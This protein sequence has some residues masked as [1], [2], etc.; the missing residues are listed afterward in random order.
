M[1]PPQQPPPPPQQQLSFGTPRALLPPL[2]MPTSPAL[3]RSGAPSTPARYD[4]LVSAAATAAT[5]AATAATAAATAAAATPARTPLNSN[6]LAAARF[7]WR[8]VG[9]MEVHPS[10][11][12]PDTMIDLTWELPARFV[13]KGALNS[14]RQSAGSGRD[15]T[16]QGDWIGLYR[17]RQRID[18][19]DGYV[20]TREVAGRMT[21]DARS[22]VAT[23]KV[24]LRTPR[25]VGMYD[26][27]YFRATN[28]DAAEDEVV[29]PLARSAPVVVEV[30]GG[31]LFE[32]IEFV[33][34]N[35]RDRRRLSSACQQLGTLLHQVKSLRHPLFGTQVAP[36]R[37]VLELAQEQERRITADIW[38]VVSECVEKGVEDD[39]AAGALAVQARAAI[40]AAKAAY[41]AAC[42]AAAGLGEAVPEHLGDEDEPSSPTAAA[43]ETD[44][45]L[46]DKAEKRAKLVA[47]QREQVGSVFVRRR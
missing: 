38:R 1:Q 47:L 21:L 35:L 19:V 12:G 17:A 30:Q 22:G 24:R 36:K 9:T 14:R 15:D 43:A 33:E 25:G 13:S 4:A 3:A 11:T 20:L 41:E 32:A 46:Q 2:A 7:E 45:L 34:K 23:G 6:K 16:T 28:P 37:P 5:A 26:F 27:R 18:V 31:A 39:V 40:A 8:P 42:E 29:L 10:V 44:P